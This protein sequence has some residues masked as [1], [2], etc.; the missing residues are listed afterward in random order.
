MRKIL[1]QKGKESSTNNSS[2][3]ASVL[4]QDHNLQNFKRNHVQPFSE[5]RKDTIENPLDQ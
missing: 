2:R 3:K 4:D 5:E 1:A